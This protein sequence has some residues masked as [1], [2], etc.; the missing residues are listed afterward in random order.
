[1]WSV[2]I[3]F[4]QVNTAAGCAGNRLRRWL[5]HKTLTSL[6]LSDYTEA[7]TSVGIS[8]VDI[9]YQDSDQNK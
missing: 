8:R 6:C 3:S 4:S 9:N 5:F 1:M 2:L 7:E